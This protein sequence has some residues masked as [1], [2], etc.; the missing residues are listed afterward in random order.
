[1]E[2]LGVELNVDEKERIFISVKDS[3]HALDSLLPGS[4]IR[5]RSCGSGN[6][7]GAHGGR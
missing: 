6:P 7:F 1:L 5:R 4:T 3:S 2:A